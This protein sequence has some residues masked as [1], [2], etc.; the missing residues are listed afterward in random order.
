MS[1]VK[2]GFN[3]YF[4]Q[5]HPTQHP[6][7]NPQIRM[8]TEQPPMKSVSQMPHNQ[9]VSLFPAQNKMPY[10]NQVNQHQ[11]NQT[12]QPIQPGLRQ[13]NQSFQTNNAPMIQITPPNRRPASRSNDRFPHLHQS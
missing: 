6:V 9:R 11:T 3:P 5:N 7:S 2:H 10:L 4:S 1:I 13:P 12:A 8:Q